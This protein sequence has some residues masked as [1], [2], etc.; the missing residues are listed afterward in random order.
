MTP[1]CRYQQGAPVQP[2]TGSLVGF[3]CLS[4]IGVMESHDQ[5]LHD[6]TANWVHKIETSM[7]VTSSLIH[8][9]IKQCMCFSVRV[10]S[11]YCQAVVSSRHQWQ[12]SRVSEL[13]P[14]LSDNFRV[15]QLYS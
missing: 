13:T 7:S 5:K 11:A 9:N 3:S 12:D 8:E 6:D 10:L 1:C 14:L 4:L 15:V 2:A